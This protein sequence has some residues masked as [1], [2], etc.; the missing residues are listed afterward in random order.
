MKINILVVG[1]LGLLLTS[2]VSQKKYSD[3]EK[4]QQDTKEL[5]DNATS[6]LSST[7]QGLSV[8]SGRLSALTDQNKFLRANNQDLIDNNYTYSKGS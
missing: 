6:K 2:C 8:A 1:V 3:L 7:E 4:L 5:L